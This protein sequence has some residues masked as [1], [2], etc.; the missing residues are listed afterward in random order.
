MSKNK[1]IALLIV[2]VIFA[3]PFQTSFM[4]V[5]H[6]DYLVQ[7]LTMAVTIIGIVV[8]ILMFNKDTGEAH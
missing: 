3:L 7:A 5:E 4:Y 1:L 6:G 2:V 8:A